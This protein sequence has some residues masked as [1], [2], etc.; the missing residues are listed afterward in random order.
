MTIDQAQH[1][2]RNRLLT[3]IALVLG[4]AALRDAYPIVMPV[5]FAAIIVA[6]VWPLKRLLD[7][8]LPSPVSYTLTMLALLAVLAG[9]AAAVYLS[10]GQVL[11]LLSG[12]WPAIVT[13]Y[14]R[15]AHAA[16][17][18]GAPMSDTLDQQRVTYVATTIAQRVYSFTTYLGFIALLVMLGLPE[19]PRIG[20]LLRAH[21]DTGARREVTD[22]IGGSAIRIR[23]YLATTFATSLL[24]GIA[25]TVFPLA[26]GLDLALVWGLLNF[27]LNF[28]PVIGNIVGIVPP[29]LYA[30]VQF[31]GVTM[32]LLVFGG[33]AALQLVISNIVYPLLQGQ[34]LSLSPVAIVVAMAFWSWIWG[35]A[36]ALIAVPLTAALVIVA[37]HFER[38]RW[39]ARLVASD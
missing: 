19:V 6:A 3:L 24:T 23:S 37:E 4:I 2:Y 36:G 7:R 27:L 30:L 35:I 5:V 9:F 21:L 31:G 15:L 8:W 25:S 33:F 10:I 17:R 1:R 14:E 38:T 34:R 22:M 39:F 29:V 32:P 13:A 20:T 16:A 11:A 12:R 28:I 18:L 26:V